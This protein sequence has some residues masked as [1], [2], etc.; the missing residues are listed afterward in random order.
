MVDCNTCTQK[1]LENGVYYCCQFLTEAF[2]WQ[3]FPKTETSHEYCWP[4]LME[5]K[6][7]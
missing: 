1:F 7:E 2:G 5:N 4:A 6:K 3:W